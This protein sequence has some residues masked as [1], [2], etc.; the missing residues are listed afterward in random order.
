MRHP[1]CDSQTC[2]DIEPPCN[3]CSCPEFWRIN[4]QCCGDRCSPACWEFCANNPDVPWC[5]PPNSCNLCPCHPSCPDRFCDPRCPEFDPCLTS[6]P[7]F[8]YCV[9]GSSFWTDA[10]NQRRAQNCPQYGP[11]YDGPRPPNSPRCFDPCTATG[12]SGYAPCEAECNPDPCGV[13]CPDVCLCGDPCNPECKGEIDWCFCDPSGP[14]CCSLFPCKPEC[15]PDICDPDG[16][17]PDICNPICNP[18]I[19][20]PTSPCYLPC[21]PE[22]NTNNCNPLCPNYDRCNRACEEFGTYDR[23]FCCA[24]CNCG[25]GGGIGDPV[26]RDITNQIDRW[27]L[28]NPRFNPDDNNPCNN[29]ISTCIQGVYNYAQD[30]YLGTLIQYDENSEFRKITVRSFLNMPQGQS[31]DCRA[32]TLSG[33]ALPQF[34][35]ASPKEGETVVE[36]NNPNRPLNVEFRVLNAQNMAYYKAGQINVYLDNRLRSTISANMRS[37]VIVRVLDGRRTMKLEMVDADGNLIPGT[38]KIVVFGY[39]YDPPAEKK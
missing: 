1:C 11:C 6:C 12:C 33:I 2:C 34:V 8:N 24:G 14:T 26:Y 28:N 32:E 18:P 20:D 7:G 17:C 15:N 5:D 27:I 35:V 37:A 9:T 3:D 22:C 39:R 25:N 23:E 36:K 31:F 16:P 30:D 4:P 10:I 19:C 21:D 29:D 38:Q 13:T